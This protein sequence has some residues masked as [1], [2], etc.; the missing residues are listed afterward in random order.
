M[1]ASQKLFQ[2]GQSIWYDNIQRKLLTDGEMRRMISEGEIRGI[3]SNPTIFMNAIAKSHDYDEALI[4]MARDGRS[5]EEIYYQLAIEDIQAAL[6]LFLPLYR[7]SGS[8]DGYVSLEVSPYKANDTAATIEEAKRLWER[9]A[10]PNLMIKIPA[11]K[12]GLPAITAGIAEGINVNVTLIFSRQRYAEVW[13]AYLIGL[14]KRLEKGLPVDSI[15]SVASF[16]V[17]RVDTKVDPRLAEIIA[18]ND[19][20]AKEAS[21]LLGRAAIANTGLVYA[22]FKGFRASDRFQKLEAKGVRPQRPLWASTSTKN[23]AYRDVVYVEE[24][25]GLDTVNTV[26]PQ[27]LTAILD[28]AVIQPGRIEENIKT[29]GGLLARLEALGISMDQVAQEL[30]EEGVRSFA[31]SFTVVLKTVDERREAIVAQ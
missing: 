21:A 10:H 24:L 12:A 6:D 13:D 26:P 25:V 27:T 29:G 31:D 4:P 20:R 15:A 2:A 11:T 16:F 7:E 9:V 5:A 14:E 23:P 3:T 8:G 17:S 19:T 22:D 30:E 28:H 18:A 1:N